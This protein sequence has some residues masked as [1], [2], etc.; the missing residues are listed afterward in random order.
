[1]DF[2]RGLLAA[3]GF[4]CSRRA[5]ST[6]QSSPAEVT[7]AHV[8]KKESSPQMC[9]LS[10]DLDPPHCQSCIS[11]EAR[12][13]RLVCGHF[14]CDQCRGH[15]INQAFKDIEGLSDYP[16]PMCNSIRQLGGTVPEPQLR[17]NSTPTV[18]VGFNDPSSPTSSP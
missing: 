1:M 4:D 15:I 7:V 5:K 12:L 16:C 3:M 8:A 10:L 18:S 2:M 9:S 6:A 13:Q 14:Y 11:Y 17:S